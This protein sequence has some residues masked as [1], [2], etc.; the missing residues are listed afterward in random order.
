MEYDWPGNV[1]ELKNVLERALL[2]QKGPLITPSEFLIRAKAQSASS[3][4]SASPDNRIGTLD[5][6]EKTYIK[7]VFEKLSNNYTQTAK[8]LGISLSTLKRKI[9]N[10]GLKSKQ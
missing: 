3:H 5:E 6:V 1:R 8:T 9:K 10:Y 2:L 7:S 4:Y